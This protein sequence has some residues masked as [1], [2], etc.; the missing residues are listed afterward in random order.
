MAAADWVV[1]ALYLVVTVG[2]GLLVGRRGGDTRDYFLASRE[3]PL[4]AVV[5]SILATETSAATFVGG[6]DSGYS[7]GFVFLQTTFGAV[8]SR[9][10]LG[11]LFIGRYHAAGVTTVYEF[12]ERRLGTPARV[13]TAGLFHVG[14][15]F[16]SGTRLYIAAFAFSQ[17]T[18]APLEW[19]I[20]AAGGLSILYGVVGGLRADVWTDVVQAVVFFGTALAIAAVLLVRVGGPGPAWEA[21]SAGGR[22]ALVDLDLRFW[23]AGFWKNPYT[24]V[25]A[26]IG[27]CTL[28]LATHGTD[29]ENVQRMLACKTS[30]ESRL[31]VVYAGLLDLPVAGLFLA[32]G[33][34][35][36]V[37]YAGRPDAPGSKEALFAFVRGEMPAGMSGLLV[38][39]IFA[40]A[41]SS[42]DSTLNAL[43]ASSVTD[44]YRPWLRPG[45]DEAHYLRVS[46]WFSLGWG[47]ALV[48]VAF[49]SA[50]YQARVGGAIY[51]LALGVMNLFYG[52]LLGAFGV[53]LFTRRGTGASTV[54][55]MAAGV[56]VAAAL[57]FGPMAS[58]AFPSIGWTWHIVAATIA[59]VLVAASVPGRPEVPAEVLVV[60]AE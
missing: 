19:A 57:R 29:Q 26:V 10:V 43:A 25:G 37:F 52:S 42:L 18:G 49:G 46:R 11:W 7:S 47:C 3:I 51:E 1:L 8:L 21:A 28:G 22:L 31:S 4:W 33:V 16:A 38:A 2:I 6:P 40:A 14:R 41:M 23:T 13:G 45:R 55:G 27:T 44:F 60:E 59:T 12:I 30:R 53:A 20:L 24:L 54:A 35:L 39:A 17:L 34:L 36:F 15:V 50:W 5:A 32:I 58:P 9:L 56:A 48:A